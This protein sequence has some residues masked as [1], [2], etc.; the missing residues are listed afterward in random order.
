MCNKINFDTDS[1]EC[2]I[3]IKIFENCSEIIYK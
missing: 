2:K 1:N 3:S